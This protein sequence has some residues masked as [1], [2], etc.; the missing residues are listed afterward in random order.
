MTKG[1]S[2][3]LVCL[4]LALIS[5][6]TDRVQEDA[7]SSAAMSVLPVAVAG[8]GTVYAGKAGWQNTSIALNAPDV[9][10][11]EE[12]KYVPAPAYAKLP[13]FADDYWYMGSKGGFNYLMHYPP[14]GLRN[15]LKIKKSNYE[16]SDPFPLTSRSKSWRR[17]NL[18]PQFD[19][20]QANDFIIYADRQV[21]EAFAFDLLPGYALPPLV[22]IPDA[23]QI[24]GE[25]ADLPGI[26]LQPNIIILET[27]A[28]DSEL[29]QRA[30]PRQRY[31][32]P[33]DEPTEPTVPKGR[34]R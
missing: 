11:A 28:Y 29:L 22:A 5:C 32:L 25:A 3:L 14:L 15:V 18:S 6:N 33:D 23:L 16:I 10:F 17:L 34:D 30:Q 8:Y 9:L 19:F 20:A 31:L 27:E 4:S 12:I 2:I 13:A 7:A 26:L 24:D 1:S 21:A